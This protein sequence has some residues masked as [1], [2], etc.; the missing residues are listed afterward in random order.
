MRFAELTLVIILITGCPPVDVSDFSQPTPGVFAWING[1]P[2]SRDDLIHA[3]KVQMVERGIDSFTSSEQL[4][5]IARQC[6]INFAQDSILIKE[7][8]KR[9]DLRLPDNVKGSLF[10]D[11]PLDLPEGFEALE[12]DRTEW[13]DRVTNRLH[14]MKIA[15][16]ITDELSKDID[17]SE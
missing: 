13:S 3:I 11:A 8:R 7:S 1:K 10:L 4:Q 5:E 16:V 14:L 9:D 12:E 2:V 17:I 6:V 15:A